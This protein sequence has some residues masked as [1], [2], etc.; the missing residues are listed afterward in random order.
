M[1]STL[2]CVIVKS[3]SFTI[4]P[5]RRLKY[6]FDFLFVNPCITNT[7]HEFF[8]KGK[9]PEDIP[10]NLKATLDYKLTTVKSCSF[11]TLPWRRFKYNFDFLFVN[12]CI[13]NTRHELSVTISK[14]RS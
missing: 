11:T 10:K 8:V 4:T 2:E 7:R 14:K 1:L 9:H 12:S 3:S 5:R 6:Y 13:T